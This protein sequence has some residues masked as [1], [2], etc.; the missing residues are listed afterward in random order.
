MGGGGGGEKTPG[1]LEAGILRIFL[2]IKKK[3]FN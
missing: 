2:I 1:V 3:T